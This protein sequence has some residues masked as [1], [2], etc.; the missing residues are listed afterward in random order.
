[1]NG[2]K[3]MVIA[4]AAVF[5]IFLV[6]GIVLNSQQ[7]LEFQDQFW[8][9]KKDGSYA[10]NG[11]QIRSTGDGEY[12][13][14]QPGRTVTAVEST[15]PDGGVRVDFSDGWAVERP[16]GADFWFELS[17]YAW[18]SDSTL[19]LTDMAQQD[20][21]FAAVA[22]GESYPFYDGTGEK[23]IGEVVE[24]FSEEGELLDHREV[25]FD[26]PELST[27]EQESIVLEDG[28]RLQANDIYNTALQNAEGEYLLDS[29]CV[30]EFRLSGRG[31]KRELLAWFLLRIGEGA[32]AARGD[33]AVVAGYVLLYVL[34]AAQMIW[35]EKLAFFGSK[36]RFR[37]EPH[38]SDS[39]LAAVYI[40]S[41][42]VM[43]CGIVMLF[44]AL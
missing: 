26:N 25:W 16:A 24:L 15:L 42:V 18:G 3:A 8:V 36:W 10:C 7:G 32:S 29:Y 4:L 1:M 13:I 21:R 5:V 20:F 6:L 12:E 40:G 28:V 2:R 41:V 35:P 31:V 14:V 39:G 43:I 17:S 23:V 44:V 19:I 33:A 11:D 9:R 37:E 22:R 27:P 30:G 34:G 38:L